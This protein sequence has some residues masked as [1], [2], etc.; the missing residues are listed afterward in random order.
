MPNQSG[1]FIVDDQDHVLHMLVSESII[2]VDDTN[3]ENTISFKSDTNMSVYD[4]QD[5]CTLDTIDFSQCI[6]KHPS[7]TTT[8]HGTYLYL[9]SAAQ[10][11]TKYDLVGGAIQLLSPQELVAYIGS[12]ITTAVPVSAN[13]PVVEGQPYP[14]TSTSTSANSISTA[15]PNPINKGTIADPYTPPYNKGTI[16]EPNPLNKGTIAE[17]NPFSKSTSSPS[18]ASTYPMTGSTEST[19]YTSNN[20]MA[21]SIKEII[22]TAFDDGFKIGESIKL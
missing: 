9:Y 7:T 16:A 3:S 21:K 10:G 19:S 14:G 11:A 8:F 12:A 18:T 22:T 2:L 15:E 4:V 17:S 1:L 13:I 6:A 20:S 5:T